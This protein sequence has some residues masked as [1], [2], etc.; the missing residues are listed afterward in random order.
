M[1]RR[2]FTLLELLVVLAIIAVLVGLLVPAVQR[3]REAA[4][5]A[6][7]QNNLK[8]LALA[9]HNYEAAHGRLPPGDSWLLDSAPFFESN[10]AVL[11]CPSRL[12]LAGSDYAGNG[13][14]YT[15]QPDGVFLSGRA[16][17]WADVTDGLSNTL[18]IS[19]KRRPI[20]PVDD[21]WSRCWTCSG[22]EILRW[23]REGA[24]PDRDVDFYK[25]F[26][27]RHPGGLNVAMADGSI[28]WVVF[29]EPRWQ[30]MGTRDGGD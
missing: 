27:S 22:A 18:L 8:Q 12:P 1:K 16:L 14:T 9:V 17:K 2:A 23:T 19:E 30:A 25:S 11:H 29:G 3:V 6:K 7:C 4:A 24:G 20:F 13:G 10:A 15:D 26:G 5:R 21:P 28:R